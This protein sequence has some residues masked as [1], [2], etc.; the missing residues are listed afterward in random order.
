MQS[1][2]LWASNRVVLSHFD[3]YSAALLFAQWE[4]TLLLPEALPDPA[5]PMSPPPDV[6]PQ[7]LGDAVRDAVITRYGLNAAELVRVAHFDEWIKTDAGP[8]RVHL[9]RFT[10]F[11][12]PAQAIAPHGGR[13]KAL[14]ELRRA[15]RLEL[16]FLRRAFDIIIGG[17][18]GTARG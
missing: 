9:L 8:V 13:F 12:A 1:P 6:A 5:E 3:S 4:E 11:A 16:T 2:D 15:D 7:Y 14:S 10:T 17:A 18:G